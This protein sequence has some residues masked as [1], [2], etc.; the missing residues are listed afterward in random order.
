MRKASAILTLIIALLLALP[1]ITC[2]D[3]GTAFDQEVPFGLT[4]K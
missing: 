1:T 3:T 4:K 2:A